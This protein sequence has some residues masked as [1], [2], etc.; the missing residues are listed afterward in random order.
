MRIRFV[1]G[2]QGCVTNV[3]GDSWKC[4]QFRIAKL[5]SLGRK[6]LA[7]RMWMAFGASHAEYMNYQWGI[8]LITSHTLY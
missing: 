4:D 1:V 7:Y 8:I 5:F 2:T 6:Y 3:I